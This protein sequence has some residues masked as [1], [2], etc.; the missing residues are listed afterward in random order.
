MSSRRRA[1]AGVKNGRPCTWSQCRWVTQ[2]GPRSGRRWEGLAE[3]AQAGAE[4]EDDRV[5]ARRLDADARGVAAVAPFVVA[6]H[7]VDPRTP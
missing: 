3:E 7:G 6:E 1:Q 4:V 5:V 2:Q